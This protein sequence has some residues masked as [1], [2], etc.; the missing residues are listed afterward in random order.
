MP[1]QPPESREVLRP[2]LETTVSIIEQSAVELAAAIRAG[3]Y[4]AR[5][6]VEAHIQRLA[7]VNPVLN[8]V[9][10]ETFERA[11]AQ[12]DIADRRLTASGGEELPTLLGVPFTVKESLAVVGLPNTAGVV[13]RKHI[14]PSANST[15]VQRILDAGAILLGLTNT[16]E[17]CMWVESVNRVYG[18]TVNAYHRKHIAGG[19]SGGEGAAIGSG[20]SPFGIA[21]DTLGSIRIPAF[22]NGVFGHRPSTGLLPLTGAWPPPHGVARMC[23]NG[24]L[25]RRAEDLMPLL[26]IMA[27][28]DGVDP[29]IAQMPLR[30]PAADFDGV[31]V[32]LID[33]AFLPGTAREV[34]RARDRA[35][36]VLA[37]AGARIERVEMKSLRRAGMFAAVH[38]A[39]EVGVSFGATMRGQ[40]ARPLHMGELIAPCGDHTAAMRLL[41]LGELLE[42]RLPRPVV[43][44]ILGATREMVAA[45][46]A[47]AGDGL[48][49]HPTM[50]TV[51]PRHGTTTGRSWR[52]NAVAPFS[53]A[54]LP[55]T[56][57][58]LGLGR[59]GLP[60]GVQ[61]VGGLGNDH[62]TIGAAL[63]LEKAAGGWV[64]PTAAEG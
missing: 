64:V 25:A 31:R 39:E 21:T 7:R 13:A 36:A 22:C 24:P 15:V 17:G 52:T 38:L 41:V 57:V 61:V 8:A 56:Q 46:T 27:G 49:L 10:V 54:G 59:A 32:V 44:R 16:S 42:A 5:Q 62:L 48:V 58:P 23:S 11:R 14:R 4:S 33:G 1:T 3:R 35:A 51:A 6:V 30:E 29:L 26:K 28:P 53:L 37:D 55:V 40:G 45:V 34:L 43:R 19:S 2:C 9:V 18:R 63:L 60:H 12:A 47:L 50:S 20:G